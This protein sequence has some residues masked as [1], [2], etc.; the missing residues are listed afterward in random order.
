MKA[1]DLIKSSM[2]LIGVLAP[3]ETPSASEA[4]D[5]FSVLNDM[6]DSWNNQR[7][8]LFAEV[9]QVYPLVVSQQGYTVGTGGDFDTTRP[10]RI[11]NYG[12][13]SLNNPAQPLELPMQI[14]TKD[15]WAAKPV[16]NIESALPREVW[17][18]GGFPLLTLY[19]WPIPN[20]AVN[21][22]IYPW[23]QI[24]EFADLSKTDYTFPPGYRRCLRY[25]LAV[26]LCAEFGAPLTPAVASIAV[27]SKG[28]IKSL[29][30]PILQMLCDPALVRPGKPIFNWLT[31]ETLKHG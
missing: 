11:T 12:I 25:N 14:L 13:I 30:E 18:D 28:E 9:R 27:S 2:R 6:V 21:M 5:A 16:K 20:V 23:V 31:G 4:Q 8:M 29:N 7:L 19:V 26:E 10:P 24:S 15:Q 3:G 22:A 17:N 1:L